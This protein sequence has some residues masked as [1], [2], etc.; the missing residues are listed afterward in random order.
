MAKISII[1]P[2]YNVEKYLR[3]CLDSLVNQTLRDIEIVCIDDASP[4]NSG[5]ILE[6]YAKKDERVKSIRAEQNLGTLHARILGMEKSVG[7]YVMFV[8]SDDFLELTACEELLGLMHKMDVDILHFGT[9]LHAGDNVSEDMRSWV[10]Q[11]LMPYE[12]KIEEKLVDA[13]FA[14]DKFD[15]NITN[16]IWRREVCE[17]AFSNLE[18]VKL[19]SSED[20]YIFFLLAY[21]AKSYYGTDK[22]YYHYNLGIGVTGGDHLS[23]E[24]FE[25]RCSGALASKLVDSF[26]QKQGEQER[27]ANASRQF[28]NKILWDCV[29]CWHN[30]LIEQ[31]YE[32]GFQ[33]LQKY[34]APNELVN[35]IARVY[36]EQGQDIFERA[37]LHTGKKIAV[38]YRYLGYD[39]MDVK[40]NACVHMLKQRGHQVWIYTDCDRGELTADK[41]GYGAEIVYLP[42]SL[43]ANWDQYETR[44][45]AI[46]EQLQQDGIDVLVYSSPT[47]H[48]YL[49]DTLLAALGDVIVV[50]MNDE[51]YLDEF[52][53]QIQDLIV[54]KEMLKGR[55]EELQRL[56]DEMKADFDSPGKMFRHF[57]GSC[58]RR[59][60][61][62]RKDKQILKG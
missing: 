7:Q 38:F 13:C 41:S 12:G 25:K 31:D 55:I 46:Y 24:Q 35:A 22:K 1:V 37:R 49:L 30:K 8:D 27:Y 5:E 14:E 11:F 42:D 54:E 50:D 36:F 47:S 16:K 21:F 60:F 51:I 19:V 62:S 33:I 23:L 32:K 9:S 34:F 48:I 44:C 53:T 20:R 2:V 26:L 40:I 61:K 17:E 3:T 28:A 4:D 56:C 43:N 57:L 52:G 10:E 18:S 39:N 45:N 59:I 6:E 29:D 15:F 58:K